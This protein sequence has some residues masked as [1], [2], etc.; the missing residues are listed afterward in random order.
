MRTP[1]EA[2]LN[3]TIGDGSATRTMPSYLRK[4]A[5]AP[6][7]LPAVALL[8]ILCVWQAVVSLFHIQPF[9]VP[10]P[11][12][13]W[14]AGVTNFSD[15]ARNASVT[16]AETLIG[17]GLSGVVGIVIAI[18]IAAW[19]LGA[20][21]VFPLLVASQ[22]IPKVA[23]APLVALW[24]GTG[25]WASALIAFVMAFFPVVINATQGL[26][27]VD[28]ESISMVEAMGGSRWTVFR[29]L[30]IPAALPHICTGLQLAMA[31]AVVGAVVGEFMGSSSGIGY[32]LIVAQGNLRTD[33]LFAA[34]IVLT[35]IGLILYY[36][37]EIVAKRLVRWN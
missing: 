2:S 21:A 12:D 15:I 29:F 31:F 23:I 19:P 14:S 24:I 32:L 20:R 13:V 8:L 33:I 10:S 25:L 11:A 30:R 16:V 35:V 6:A 37:V 7:F 34:L 3:L 27:S 5:G 22:V 9:L 26:N 4:I 18:F 36:A 1:K 28:P 17:F